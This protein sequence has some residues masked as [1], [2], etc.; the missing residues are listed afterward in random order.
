MHGIRVLRGAKLSN[1]YGYYIHIYC[2][3]DI[4]NFLRPCHINLLFL[5]RK[6]IILLTQLYITLLIDGNR[7]I[8]WYANKESWWDPQNYG[9]IFQNAENRVWGSPASKGNFNSICKCIALM[10]GMDKK[11]VLIWHRYVQMFTFD[12]LKCMFDV[13]LWPFLALQPLY[14]YY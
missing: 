6:L 10:N 7:N 13:H 2:K 11:T 3:I 4:P 9:K 8:L 1:I 5:Q 12:G 14:R